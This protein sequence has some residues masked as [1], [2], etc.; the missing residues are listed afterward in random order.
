MLNNDACVGRS[1]LTSEV[2]KDRVMVISLMVGCRRTRAEMGI[3]RM[4]KGSVWLVMLMINYASAE[5]LRRRRRQSWICDMEHNTG[6]VVSK[7]LIW[8][9]LI[10]SELVVYRQDLREERDILTEI[11]HRM[12][13]E[14]QEEVIIMAVKEC[15]KSPAKSIWSSKWSMENGLLY[16]RGKV[17]VPISELHCQIL[18]LCHDSKLA[19]HP[20][21]WKTLKLVSRNYWW[22][23]MSRYIGKYVST[24]DMCLQ[25]MLYIIFVKFFLLIIPTFWFHS[26]HLLSLNTDYS[27]TCYTFC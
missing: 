18:A 17:Y 16:Y 23:Q 10:W 2:P 27:S 5:C 12:Q 21:R 8:S 19:G 25:T 9:D 3:V 13:A 20:G 26:W 22:P 1:L 15:K 4:E 7:I 6:R 14:D 24:C 11:K